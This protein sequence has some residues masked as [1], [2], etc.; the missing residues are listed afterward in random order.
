MICVTH[1][2][3]C[4]H[5]AGMS[6]GLCHFIILVQI[7]MCHKPVELSLPFISLSVGGL[8]L[9]HM[10]CAVSAADKSPHTRYDRKCVVGNSDSEATSHF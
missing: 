4:C 8:S 3:S 5:G 6:A 2:A 10:P 9:Q 7:D 1:Y